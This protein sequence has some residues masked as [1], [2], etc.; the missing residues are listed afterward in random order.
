MSGASANPVSFNNNLTK[1]IAQLSTTNPSSYQ[2]KGNNTV[3]F[4]GVSETI[5]NSIFALQLDPNAYSG[6]SFITTVISDI[7]TN[8][9]ANGTNNIN[10]TQRYVPT[11][12]RYVSQEINYNTAQASNAV[13]Q[14][15]GSQTDTPRYQINNGKTIGTVIDYATSPFPTQSTQNVQKYLSGAFISSIFTPSGAASILAGPAACSMPGSNPNTYTPG[16][17]L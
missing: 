17:M 12:N 8:V 1:I 15:I 10:T 6:G 11:I 9:S 5:L 13:I 3:T 14:N 2:I 4:H 16:A 7:Q